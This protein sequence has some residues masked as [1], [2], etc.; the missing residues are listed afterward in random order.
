MEKTTENSV[1]IIILTWNKIQ[2]TKYCLYYLYKYTNYPNW[3]LIVVD[4]GSTDET[5]QFLKKFQRTHENCQI[6]LNSRNL[7]FAK[8]N[9][10]GIK[11]AKGQYIVFLNN[12]VFVTANWLIELVNCS[13][14][15]PNVGIVGTKLIYP[16]NRRIQHAGVV[17]SLRGKPFHVYRNQKSTDKQVNIQKSYN[18]VTAACMLVKR[19]LIEE[20]GG[21]DER[22]KIGGYEDVDL[23]LRARLKKYI[24]LYCPKSEMLHYEYGSSQ[25]I[26]RFNEMAKRNFSIFMKKW[27][28]L[29]K[30]YVDSALTFSSKLKYQFL[31]L[32]LLEA[33]KNLIPSKIWRNLQKMLSFVIS[34]Y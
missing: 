20:L 16:Q 22:F 33:I 21:F 30:F 7:G 18:A 9:N 24:I 28:Y 27:G 5:Q 13:K 34:S 26:E 19:N 8:G 2:F 1:T 3:D 23:C 15:D 32:Q 31:S 17:F 10:Q 6:I 4:N 11:Q 12:D 25:Q 14:S 29:F